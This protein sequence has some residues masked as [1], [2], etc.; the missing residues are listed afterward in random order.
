MWQIAF[1]TKL[2]RKFFNF[3][4]SETDSDGE[5]RSRSM[6]T[7]RMVMEGLRIDSDGGSRG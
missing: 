3:F 4:T 6:E 5:S 2:K 7:K 1:M